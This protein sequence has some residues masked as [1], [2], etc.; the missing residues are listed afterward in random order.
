MLSRH[1]DES[2]EYTIVFWLGV[3]VFTTCAAFCKCCLF[4]ALPGFAYV[5]RN[6]YRIEFHMKRKINWG[7]EPPLEIKLFL[8]SFWVI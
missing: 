4:W 1:S 7:K 5:F 8:I 6:Q 3:F 2:M